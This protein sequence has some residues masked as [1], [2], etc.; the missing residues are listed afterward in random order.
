[1]FAEPYARHY[2][3]LYQRKPYKDEINFVYELAGQPRQILDLGCGSANYWKY[4]PFGTRMTGIELSSDMIAQSQYKPL[5]LKGDV[6]KFNY[7]L[8]EPFDCATALFDVMNY[9]P[10]IE[11]IDRLP[12]KRGGSLVFDVLMPGKERFKKTILKVGELKRTI[13]P[14]E[15]TNKKVSLQVTL[16]DNGNSHTET[17][18]LYL[19]AK[20]DFE[21]LHNFEVKDIISTETWQTWCKLRK[22]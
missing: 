22:K 12:L 20:S 13:K 1:M 9:V 19:W 21:A 17:H 7:E 16:E 8:F 14:I 6:T 2:D 5:I 3:E 15:Q 4:F 11:W 18:D 10:E